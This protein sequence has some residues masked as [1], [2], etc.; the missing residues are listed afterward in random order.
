MVT[1]LVSTFSWVSSVIFGKLRTLL[2]RIHV[3]AL[4]YVAEAMVHAPKVNQ[5]IPFF[6]VVKKL[7]ATYIRACHCRKTPNC[8][9][10]R[11]HTEQ[12][13]EQNFINCSILHYNG[14]DSYY[15]N[16]NPCA[17]L[18]FSRQRSEGSMAAK[19]Y[20][21]TL[22]FKSKVSIPYRGACT[23]LRIRCCMHLYTK[24]LFHHQKSAATY[25][26]CIK[27]SNAC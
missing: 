14:L 10:Q 4:I 1:F 23:Y 15:N 6:R 3:H 2:P 25:T 9:M 24:R 21:Y 8:A 5:N 22:N 11:F 18:L 13:F 7:C 27:T 20:N 12:K 19:R 17:M 16:N 26:V